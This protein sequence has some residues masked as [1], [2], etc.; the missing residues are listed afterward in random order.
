M[1]IVVGVEKRILVGWDRPTSSLCHSLFRLQIANSLIPN[2]LKFMCVCPH[3]CYDNCLEFCEKCVF[4][5]TICDIVYQLNAVV[6]TGTI[7]AWD[8]KRAS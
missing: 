6:L 5:R 3:N 4:L 7:S 8:L 1:E 2:D